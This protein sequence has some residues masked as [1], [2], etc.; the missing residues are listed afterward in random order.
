[1]MSPESEASSLGSIAG[2]TPYQGGSGYNSAK[3][4]VRDFQRHA[5]ARD[6]PLSNLFENRAKHHRSVP[7]PVSGK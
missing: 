7:T 1:M 3:H 6:H 2:W 4:G 5:L